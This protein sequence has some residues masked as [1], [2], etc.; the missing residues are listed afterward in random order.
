MEILSEYMTGCVTPLKRPPNVPTRDF[1]Y[2]YGGVEGPFFSM[3]VGYGKLEKLPVLGSQLTPYWSGWYSKFFEN[4]KK[5]PGFDTASLI[6][7]K[8]PPESVLS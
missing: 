8:F 1:I 2:D 5:M 7:P 3:L 6:S 4:P